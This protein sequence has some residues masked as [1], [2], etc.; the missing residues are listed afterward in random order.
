MRMSW[1]RIPARSKKFSLTREVPDTVNSFNCIRGIACI[2]TDL[3]FVSVDIDECEDKNSC[4]DKITTCRNTNGSYECICKNKGYEYKK[5]E[6]SCVDINECDKDPW[7]CGENMTCHNSQ[8]SYRC[9]CTLKNYTE[10]GN[11]C[12]GEFYIFISF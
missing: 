4:P 9:V 11:V 7:P 12:V 5:A 6:R 1:V 3:F 2:S 10:K 8:G